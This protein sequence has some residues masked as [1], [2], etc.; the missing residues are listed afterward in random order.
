MESDL[1][2]TDLG[3]QSCFGPDTLLLQHT[4]INVHGDL[5]DHVLRSLQAGRSQRFDKTD[6]KELI[7]EEERKVQLAC[8]VLAPVLNM[9]QVGKDRVAITL[10]IRK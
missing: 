3:I 6:E 2:L 5:L 10:Q 7:K 1:A 4:T 8:E 9:G